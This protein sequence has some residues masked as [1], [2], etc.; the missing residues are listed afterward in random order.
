M[1]N[2][3]ILL[4]LGA[5]FAFVTASQ[6]S[7][8]FADQCSGYEKGTVIFKNGKTLETY[9]YIDYCNPQLFQSGLRTIDAKAYKKYIRGKRI[10]KKAIEK[11]KLKKITS[12]TLESGQH[13]RTVK[14]ANPYSTKKTDLIPSRLLLEVVS[15]GKVV[16]YKKYYRT[17]N[18]FIYRPVMDSH[19][20][21]GPEHLV[22]MKNNFEVLIQKDPSKN[23]KN[24]RS[25]NLKQYFGDH[26][27]ILQK[28]LDGHYSFREQLQRSP[29]FSANCDPEFL[30]SL[31]ELVQDYNG[32]ASEGISSTNYE[33]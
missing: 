3:N 18:G 20:R 25:I 22:F 19:F 17:K 11:L 15:D 21:G 30:K 1:L 14:Y 31:Q 2:K 10:K 28:Y 5:L 32:S 24:I 6:A 26:P 27:G 13:Y 7:P 33:N 16:V 9:V 8:L 4:T 29:S 12:V 23:P